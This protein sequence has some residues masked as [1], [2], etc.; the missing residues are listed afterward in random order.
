MAP[1]AVQVVR[2]RT[3][4]ALTRPV[5]AIFWYAHAAPKSSSGRIRGPCVARKPDR[6]DRLLCRTFLQAG[7]RSGRRWSCCKATAA[8]HNSVN[9]SG[10]WRWSRAVVRRVVGL[11]LVLLST[12]LSGH[13]LLPHL[14]ICLT[15]DACDY[16]RSTSL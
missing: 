3:E 11:L 12:S 16:L 5:R 10:R 9:R 13:L 8:G 1:A 15:V 7:N 4:V 6:P 2:L 14:S